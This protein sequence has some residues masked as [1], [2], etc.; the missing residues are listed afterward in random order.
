MT[1]F[2]KYVATPFDIEN[3]VH[4]DHLIKLWN[5]FFNESDFILQSPEWK[6]LGFQSDNPLSDFRAS[7]FFCLKNLIYFSEKYTSK[8]KYLL[9]INETRSGAYYPFAIASFNVTMM[10]CELLGWGWKKPG[11]STA[12]DPVVYPRI[13]SML[14]KNEEVSMEFT[15]NV[16]SELYCLA[17]VEMDS[18]WEVSKATYMDFPVVITNSQM[19]LEKLIRGFSGVEDLISYN[20]HKLKE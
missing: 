3:E 5:I 19:R 4:R 18:E 12:K 20:Q 1:E 15:E 9:D 7:G 10:L 13:V 17:M 2:Q 6:K 16:F 14:W 8:F 11:V